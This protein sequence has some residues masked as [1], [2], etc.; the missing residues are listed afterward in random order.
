MSIHVI[1]ELLDALE[2]N[3]DSDSCPSDEQTENDVIMT[4]GDNKAQQNSKRKTMKLHGK[5][6]NQEVTIRV[7]S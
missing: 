5:V 4:I 3:D 2:R 1:E 6:G 7:D